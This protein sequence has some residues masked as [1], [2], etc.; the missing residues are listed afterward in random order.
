MD[1]YNDTD[2]FGVIHAHTC[3]NKLDVSIHSIVGE[4]DEGLINPDNLANDR[5]YTKRDPQIRNYQAR[6][7]ALVL[8]CYT[9]EFQIT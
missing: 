8:Y 9:P 2:G 5:Y 3:A 6:F 4:D 1:E 7:V